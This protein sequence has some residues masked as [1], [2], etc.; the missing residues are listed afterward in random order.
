MEQQHSLLGN[1]EQHHLDMHKH[2]VGQVGMHRVVLG[3]R[4]GLEGNLV[5]LD[6]LVVLGEDRRLVDLEE[7]K[8][9]VGLAR[10][11]IRKLVVRGIRVVRFVHFARLVGLPAH[12]VVRLGRRLG[13]LVVVGILVV[14]L[15][16]SLAVLVGTLEEA[17]LVGLVE[18]GGPAGTQEEELA[19]L[20]EEEDPAGTLEGELAGAVLEGEHH[21]V[22][23][24]GEG[25]DFEWEEVLVGTLEVEPLVVVGEDLAGTLAG[26]DL[27]I[28]PVVGE[29]GLGTGL[30][31][32]EDL[33][34]GPV[35][36]EEGLGIG[37]VVG[38]GPA[39]TLVGE[40]PAGILGE[41]V[42]EGGLVGILE[43][44][45]VGIPVEGPV[46]SLGEEELV[47]LLVEQDTP[48][49]ERDHLVGEVVEKDYPARERLVEA[50][51]DAR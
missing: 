15:V 18:E 47:K 45:L 27:G 12:L 51:V 34:T 38:E 14:G 3:N 19:G 39:G 22:G 50:G 40:G 43:E 25:R 29:E 48:E 21:F 41:E 17:F 10:E 49:E 16:V 20:V 24:L 23:I 28:D 9:R 11:G 35:V 13:S 4:V 7:D 37:L 44:G 42:L 31:V 36:G 6:N 33:G 32:G 30:V 46:G 2:L 5:V 1:L 8:R 26:E